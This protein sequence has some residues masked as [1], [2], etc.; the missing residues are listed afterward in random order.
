LDILED[1]KMNLELSIPLGLEQ[2]LIEVG[3]IPASPTEEIGIVAVTREYYN[4]LP[5]YDEETQEYMF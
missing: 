5:T 1:E 2:H 3:V 4:R